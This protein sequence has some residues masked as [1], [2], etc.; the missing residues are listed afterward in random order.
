MALKENMV[1]LV[2]G[3]TELV[4]CGIRDYLAL[5]PDEGKGARWVFVGVEEFDLTKVECSEFSF[6][7]GGCAITEKTM[8]VSKIQQL[9][10]ELE[11][12]L[13]T[14]NV[15]AHFLVEKANKR[16]GESTSTFPPSRHQ[17]PQNNKP[18]EDEPCNLRGQC[19]LDHL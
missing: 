15:P 13:G 8:D 19:N 4:G 10:D 3:G 14:L 18:Q 7:F 5:H 2:T 1:V 11:T 17:L 6:P 16:F 12:D 9:L